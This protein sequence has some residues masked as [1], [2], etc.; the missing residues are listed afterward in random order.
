[1][2]WGFFLKLL[3]YFWESGN[4]K[5]NPCIFLPPIPSLCPSQHLPAAPGRAQGVRIHC[6]IPGG[7]TKGGGGGGGMIF[8]GCD[9]SQQ[10]QA[11]SADIGDSTGCAGPKARPRPQFLPF[12]II[13]QKIKIKIFFKKRIK[14]KEVHPSAASV[15]HL[16]LT[17]PLD[18]R[19]GFCCF[20][21]LLGFNSTKPL[22]DSGV[23]LL[24]FF[25]EAGKEE[26]LHK[27]GEGDFLGS[28]SPRKRCF[29]PK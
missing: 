6:G 23:W 5:N 24:G 19:G 10:F 4:I 7:R 22:Q 1:M 18:G 27:S 16:F 29:L 26:K 17:W 13:H 3:L 20:I 28:L 9:K 21:F 12:W 14:I 11:W 25:W 8:L 15:F 2:V